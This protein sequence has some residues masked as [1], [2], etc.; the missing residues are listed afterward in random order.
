MLMQKQSMHAVGPHATKQAGLFTSFA[1][2]GMCS[3][4]RAKIFAL[5][6]C[7]WARLLWSLMLHGVAGTLSNGFAWYGL[8]MLIA[9]TGI[10]VNVIFLH[11]DAKHRS[12]ALVLDGMNLGPA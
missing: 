6:L 4:I 11:R 8:S 12:V 7:T 3:G 10:L 5:V 9:L 2:W 1:V